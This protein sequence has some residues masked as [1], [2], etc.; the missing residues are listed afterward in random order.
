MKKTLVISDLIKSAKEFCTCQSHVY[1]AEL[2]G[3][4]DGKAVGTF[5]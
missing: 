3:I 1:R 2:F 5:V 4:T